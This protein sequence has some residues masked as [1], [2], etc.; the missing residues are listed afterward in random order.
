ML[1]IPFFEITL[2]LLVAILISVR[3]AVS[4]NN[5]HLDDMKS[6]MDRRSRKCWSASKAVC[7]ITVRGSPSWRS[8]A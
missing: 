4:T 8:V 7:R 1:T 5:R 6:D 3:A 2:P